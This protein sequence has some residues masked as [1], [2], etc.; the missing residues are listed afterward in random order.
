MLRG[1]PSPFAL[2]ASGSIETR[3][4]QTSMLLILS[5]AGS[6]T[7]PSQFRSRAGQFPWQ[8]GEKGEGREE[9]GRGP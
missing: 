5:F 9:R 6:S 3:S 7:P 4:A 2:L 8:C 1:L